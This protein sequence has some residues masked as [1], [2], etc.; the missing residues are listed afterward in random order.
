[1]TSQMTGT[2]YEPTASVESKGESVVG[3]SNFETF[4]REDTVIEGLL[5]G[6][7]RVLLTPCYNESL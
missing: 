5:S 4:E 1:M 3:P 6:L 2:N 7:Y